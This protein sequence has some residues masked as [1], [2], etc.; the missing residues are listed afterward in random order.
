MAQY[1][2]LCACWIANCCNWVVKGHETGTYLVFFDRFRSQLSRFFFLFFG[3]SLAAQGVVEFEGG[4]SFDGPG[5]GAEGAAA[6]E[7]GLDLLN[8]PLGHGLIYMVDPIGGQVE[9]PG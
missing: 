1:P 9:G 2:K 4:G 8:F 3:P 5:V 6:L 7:A